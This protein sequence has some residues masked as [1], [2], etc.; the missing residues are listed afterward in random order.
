MTLESLPLVEEN[1]ERLT[2]EAPLSELQG[3]AGAL[4][5]EFGRQYQFDARPSGASITRT[6]ADGAAGL[7]GK[8]RTAVALRLRLR[9][10]RPEE[11]R[12][13]PRARAERRLEIPG[14]P[15]LHPD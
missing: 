11:L 9:P 8:R 10:D 1:A 6:C 13:G 3:R 15:Q 14:R 12:L 7:P 4:A 2:G 5:R